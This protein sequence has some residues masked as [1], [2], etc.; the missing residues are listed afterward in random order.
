MSTFRAAAGPNV[1]VSVVAGVFEEEEA[2]VAEA[3]VDCAG[4]VAGRDGAEE[5]LRL[6]P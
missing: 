4:N 1:G 6:S 2:A 3:L 5:R